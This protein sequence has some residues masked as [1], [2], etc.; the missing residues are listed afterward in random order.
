MKLSRNLTSALR[1]AR[2]LAANLDEDYIPAM[3]CA[4]KVKEVPH[5]PRILAFDSTLTVGLT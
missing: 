4:A 5:R 2:H 3:P 1:I